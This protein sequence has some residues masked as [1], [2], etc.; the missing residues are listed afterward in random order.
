MPSVSMTEAERKLVED[1]V[2]VFKQGFSRSPAAQRMTEERFAYKHFGNPE[3]FDRSGVVFYEADTPVSIFWVM[4]MNAVKDGQ[5]FRAAQGGDLAVLPGVQKTLFFGMH[6][7]IERIIRENDAD[8]NFGFPGVASFKLLQALGQRHLGDFYLARMHTFTPEMRLLGRTVTPPP[9]VARL[10][11]RFRPRAVRRLARQAR[12]VRVR[13]Y[14]A[15][16]FS[17]DD[18]VR[19]NASPGRF[20]IM[21]SPEFYAWKLDGSPSGRSTYSKAVFPDGSLAG[22]VIVREN[23]DRVGDIIDWHLFG[24][25]ESADRAILA[26]L[27]VPFLTRFDRLDAYYLN[28]ATGETELFA[29]LRLRTEPLVRRGRFI[30]R[31]YDGME[32]DGHVYHIE[33]WAMRFLDT[34]QVLN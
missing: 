8:L 7:E 32:S 12:G 17:A 27:L 31:A 19:M 22:F 14:D 21:R 16:P 33:N 9:G 2:V 13:T 20:R 5:V 3:R 24:A 26:K 34:D 23:E 6:R 28:P 29:G 25:D 10:L 1:A 11:Q 18:Y 30:L 15:A 4:G